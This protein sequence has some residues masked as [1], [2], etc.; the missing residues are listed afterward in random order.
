MCFMAEVQKAIIKAA[1]LTHVIDHGKHHHLVLLN[2]FNVLMTESNNQCCSYCHGCCQIFMVKMK[3][4]LVGAYTPY[5]KEVLST[6][7]LHFQD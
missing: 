6:K 5:I 1:L 7:G 4:V 2:F 3:T